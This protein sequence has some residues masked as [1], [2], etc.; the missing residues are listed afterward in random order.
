MHLISKI[1]RDILSVQYVLR[2]GVE[3]LMKLGSRWRGHRVNKEEWWSWMKKQGK[4][5]GV[6]K[7]THLYPGGTYFLWDHISPQYQSS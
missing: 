3:Q 7:A 1:L 2:M 5:E 4:G 6:S